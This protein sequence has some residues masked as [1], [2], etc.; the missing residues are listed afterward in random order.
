M[1]Y[2]L[3]LSELTLNMSLFNEVHQILRIEQHLEMNTVNIPAVFVYH[4]FNS[5]I[6]LVRVNTNEDVLYRLVLMCTF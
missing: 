3:Q 2:A 5:L 4:Q 1:S 6:S